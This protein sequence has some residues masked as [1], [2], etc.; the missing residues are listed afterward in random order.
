VRSDYRDPRTGPLEVVEPFDV[1]EH[2]RAQ[3]STL[4]MLSPAQFEEQHAGS[5]AKNVNGVLATLRIANTNN[6]YNNDND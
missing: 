3:H 6:D 4:G 5:R 2:L 1:L